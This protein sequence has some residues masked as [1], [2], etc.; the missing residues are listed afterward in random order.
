MALFQKKGRIWYYRLMNLEGKQQAFRGCSD[1]RETERMAAAKDA[2]FARIRASLIDAADQIRIREGHRP[3]GEHLADWK[4]DLVARNTTAKH[5]NQSTSQVS[6]L[7]ALMMG[8]PLDSIDG[9]NASRA[10]REK[11]AR[12]I[13][14][15]L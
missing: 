10:S 5:A 1:R 9:P 15:S 11:T 4:T 3:L 7:V 12:E 14:R 13:E 8:E 6:R 2:E